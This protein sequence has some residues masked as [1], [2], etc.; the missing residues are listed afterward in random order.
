MELTQEYIF[1]HIGEQSLKI[2]LL[3]KSNLELTKKVA[4]L[5][6]QIEELKKD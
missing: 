4:E 1:A 3:E 2:S 6:R 5:N